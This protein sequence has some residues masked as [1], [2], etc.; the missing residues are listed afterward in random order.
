MD[1]QVDSQGEWTSKDSHLNKAISAFDKT[2]VNGLRKE[3]HIY[4]HTEQL[5]LLKTTPLHMCRRRSLIGY[6]P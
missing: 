1:Q 4:L 6:L 5:L 3:D 2:A